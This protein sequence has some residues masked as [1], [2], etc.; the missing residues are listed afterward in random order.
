MWGALLATAEF[1]QHFVQDLVV[2]SVWRS[3]QLY[4]GFKISL[5]EFQVSF[6][7][8][9]VLSLLLLLC[10][11]VARHLRQDFSGVESYQ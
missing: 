8:I 2:D 5:F 1:S 9:A 6:S 4:A 10:F 11:T 7:F 3:L